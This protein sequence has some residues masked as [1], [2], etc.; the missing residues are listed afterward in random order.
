MWPWGSCFCFEYVFWVWIIKCMR[1]HWTPGPLSSLSGLGMRLALTLQTLDSG[2]IHLLCNSLWLTPVKMHQVD[3]WQPHSQSVQTLITSTG[4]Y[5]RLDSYPWLTFIAGSCFIP[6]NTHHTLAVVAKLY[7]TPR[8]YGFTLL[9]NCSD[10]KWLIA[11]LQ[12]WM[13]LRSSY[14]IWQ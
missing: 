14:D 12:T 9:G 8:S 7:M 5:S 10:F 13:W 6:V 3:K 11:P 1:K 2:C 4:S